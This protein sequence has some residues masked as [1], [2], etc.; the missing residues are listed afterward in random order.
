MFDL[1]DVSLLT[2]D[3]LVCPDPLGRGC[4]PEFVTQLHTCFATKIYWLVNIVTQI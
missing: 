4:R 3:T 2:W 1:A